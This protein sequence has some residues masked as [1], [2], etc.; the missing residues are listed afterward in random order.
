MLISSFSGSLVALS[1]LVR[2][3]MKGFKMRWSICIIMNR[4]S[5]DV[6]LVCLDESKLNQLSKSSE[7]LKIC[8]IMKL[9]KLQSSMRLF[10]KGVPVSSRRLYALILLDCL[11]VIDSLFFNLWASSKV[12]RYQFQAFYLLSL[13]RSVTYSSAS[14]VVTQTSNVPGFISSRMIRS[15][16]SLS[17]SRLTT[18]SYGAQTLNSFIQFGMVLLG[19]IIMCGLF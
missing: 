3:S 13:N 1:S 9:S 11:M 12:N 10:C 17:A 16:F 14:Y 8:G 19:P 2:L 18:R 4:A 15:R 5:S 6:F 7:S